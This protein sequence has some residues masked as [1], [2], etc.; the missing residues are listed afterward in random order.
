MSTATNRLPQ[1]LQ[2]WVSG[3]LRCAFEVHLDTVGQA[4][5]GTFV[6]SLSEPGA[7]FLYEVTNIP[8]AMMAV[9]L[10]PRI[11]FLLVERLLGGGSISPVPE[12][13]LSL[14]ESIVTRIVTDRVAKEVSTVWKDQMDLQLEFARFEA[15][16]ELIEMAGRD[17]DV[18]VTTLQ[19]QVEDV[20]GVIHFALPF[21]VLESFLT[22]TLHSRIKPGRPRPPA[23]R[24]SE[25]TQIEGTVRRASVVVA[26]RLPETRAPLQ[27]LADLKPGDVLTVESAAT[28]PIEVHVAGKLRFMGMQGRLGAHLGVQITDVRSVE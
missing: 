14:L 1:A 15:A 13:A 5:Y 7:T 6:D 12:R 2:R 8:G 19:V 17:D 20:Q 27:R 22:P 26:A 11:A 4:S 9:S 25:R 28:A 24:A 10:D 16:R 23:E 3:R 18:L 21:P